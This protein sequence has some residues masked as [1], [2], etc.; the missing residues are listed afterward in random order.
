VRP[1]IFIV[2]LFVTY[3]VLAL[4]L[5]RIQIVEHDKYQ[6]LADKQHYKRVET[7]ALRGAILDRNGK[8]LA[9]SLKTNSVYAN[10]KVI[11]D[12]V[13]VA[14]E[15]SEALGLEVSRVQKALDRDKKFAWIKREVNKREVQAI[16]ERNI[17]GVGILEECRRSYPCG[18]LLS[19][20]IGFVDIDEK[21]LEGVEFVC[22]GKLSGKPGLKVITRDGLQR[23]IFDAGNPY[24]S[25]VDGDSVVLTVDL[26]LQHILEEELDKA[27]EE[28][29]PVSATAIAMDPRTGEILALSNRPTFD[30]NHFTVSSADQR[31]NRA[32]TD[33]Y[34]PGSVIK[35][36]VVSGVLRRKLVGPK[37][38]V[39]CSNGV[40]K[41]RGRTLR[42]VHPY[43]N[44]TVEEIL[45]HSS[46]IGMSKLA[47]MDGIEGLYKNLKLFGLGRPTGVGL[48]GEVG[49]TLRHHKKWTSYSVASVAM[50]YELSVTPL[51]MI[52][53]YCALANDGVLLKPRIVAA[54]TDNEGGMTKKRFGTEVRNRVLS[55]EL[56]SGII[57]PVLARVVAEGT[58]R[59]AK[60]DGYTVAGKTG[61]SKKLN[62]NGKGYGGAGYISSFIAYA[63]ADDPKLC[64]LVM[65]NEP[66]GRAYYGGTVAAPVVRE[67][68]RRSLNYM[69]RVALLAGGSE[70]LE[71]VI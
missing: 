66:H 5:G 31:R 1:Y 3:L 22:D 18:T 11:E 65:V 10:P 51:Q 23:P 30:P 20:V 33:S 2:A 64:V 24:T 53:A 4:Q 8:I 60:L 58:G 67:I 17:A 28:W 14:N 62:P 9:H 35:P 38:I 55:S 52:T 7:P 48:P 37:D 59:R 70:S 39:F 6:K 61:T 15:L 32:I 12:K 40:Y 46:N 16:E 34:E 45:V 54:I 49:G 44:L 68:L 29:K 41:I 27:F 42:D 43:G 26:A 71:E 13:R 19:H 56:A 25:P 36:L 57:T 63:P 50:G 21:G 47:A 69:E